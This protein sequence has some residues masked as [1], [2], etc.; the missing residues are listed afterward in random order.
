MIEVLRR[1]IES[2]VN[3]VLIV[4]ERSRAAD[5]AH[6]LRS[7]DYQGRARAKPRRGPS[8]P[9]QQGLGVLDAKVLAESQTGRRGTDE[10]DSLLIQHHGL[11]LL[12]QDPAASKNDC[13]D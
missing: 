6:R 13:P 11:D 2:A 5:A 7:T 12:E 4:V 9:V 3:G 1:S 8:R 10:L